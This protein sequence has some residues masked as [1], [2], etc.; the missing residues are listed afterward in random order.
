MFEVKANLKVS[1]KDFYNLILFSLKHDYSQ[2]VKEIDRENDIKP[3]LKY[4]KQIQYGDKSVKSLFRVTDLVQDE[5]Y[6]AKVS[7]KFGDMLIR[8]LLE[9][10]NANQITVTY[11]EEFITEG[12]VEKKGLATWLVNR[13]RKKSITKALKTMER[14]IILDRNMP[15]SEKNITNK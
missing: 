10:K 1:R 4:N 6:Q 12:A 11:Q 13:R 9:D 8:Y 5:F 7:N 14:Q 3:G 15:E 2:N